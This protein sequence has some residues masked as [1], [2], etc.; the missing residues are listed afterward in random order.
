[1]SDCCSNHPKTGKIKK[2]DVEKDVISK[3]LVGGYLH[4]TGKSDLKKSKGRRR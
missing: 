1:M 4:K 2:A 3:S